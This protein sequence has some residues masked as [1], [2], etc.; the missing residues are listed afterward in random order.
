MPSLSV[1]PTAALSVAGVTDYIQALLEQDAQLSRLWVMGEVSSANDRG[2]HIFFTLQD[3]EANAAI[4]AVVWRSQRDKLAML[5]RAGEQVFLLGQMRVYPARGQYQLSTLQLLPA[6]EGLQ[7]L[8]KRQLYQRLAAEG[9]FDDEHKRPLPAYPECI[10]VVTSGQAAAWGDIQQTL[11]QR[12]PGLRVLLSIATVQGPQAP[13]AVAAAIS[14]AIRDRRAELILLARGGGAREDLDAFDDEPV[15][16]AIA[17]SPL[18]II[19]GIGHKRDETLADLAADACAHTPTAAAAW[20]VPHIDDLWIEQE[21]RQQRLKGALQSAVQMHY[22]QV[23]DLRRRLEQQQLYRQ[24]EQEQ[25]R[26][27]W[28]KQQLRQLVQHRLQTAQ[29]HCRYLSQALQSLDPEAVLKRGYAILRDRDRLVSAAHQ[30]AVGDHLHIQ[31]AQ[32]ELTVEVKAQSTPQSPSP[33][34]DTAEP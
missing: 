2:G 17:E 30:V 28:Q 6:G 7:A 5:P 15:V 27:T 18:P 23:A 3:P 19:T 21:T 22:E 31:L 20:A 8:K 24:I 34:R 33:P 11:R 26:L 9:L 32:G 10:A 12:Q 13:Q 29:Q 4:Q 16:R 14:R 1:V 25:Q